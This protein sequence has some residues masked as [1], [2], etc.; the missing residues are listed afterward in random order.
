MAPPLVV[1]LVGITGVAHVL[2]YRPPDLLAE[3][4]GS[5]CPGTSASHRPSALQP[6]LRPCQASKSAVV[7]RRLR[8]VYIAINTKDGP[9][10]LEIPRKRPS[11]T[12]FTP[13]AGAG[14]AGA[15]RR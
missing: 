2:R 1:C 3:H 7:K 12:N 13:W 5:C 4:V 9:V 10:V 15:T 8:Y 6:D 11:Q 14:R